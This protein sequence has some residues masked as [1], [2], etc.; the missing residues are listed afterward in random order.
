[1]KISHP[2]ISEPEKNS[3][4]HIGTKRMLDNKLNKL[5]IYIEDGKNKEVNNERSKVIQNM[6]VKMP[7]R[8]PY[9]FAKSASKKDKTAQHNHS[10]EKPRIS[11]NLPSLKSEFR[12]EDNIAWMKQDKRAFLPDL[13]HFKQNDSRPED[14]EVEERALMNLYA[15]D[16]DDLRVL[17]MLSS[18]QDLYEHKMKQ[19]LDM[20]QMRIEAEK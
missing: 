15:K 1:M 11:R 3:N 2:Y 17:N 13:G 4:R 6:N 14:M 12:T 9:R 10:V 8:D 7:D 20:S 16:F 19:Y 5:K 18:N